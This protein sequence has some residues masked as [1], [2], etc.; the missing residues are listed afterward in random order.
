MNRPRGQYPPDRFLLIFHFNSTVTHIKCIL[1]R[2]AS[3]FTEFE[4]CDWLITTTSWP[5]RGSRPAKV[6][7]VII[8]VTG[9]RSRTWPRSRRFKNLAAIASGMNRLLLLAK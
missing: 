6:T 4:F 1:P 9:S 8:F 3:L 5:L 7:L 2:A